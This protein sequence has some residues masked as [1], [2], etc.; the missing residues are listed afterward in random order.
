MSSVT[1]P[2]IL[3]A[4]GGAWF[5]WRCAACEEPVAYAWEPLPGDP[6]TE[7]ADAYLFGRLC[8]RCVLKAAEEVGGAPEDAL[9]RVNRHRRLRAR[10]RHIESVWR[11]WS[12]W[13]EWRA[14]EFYTL[15][16]FA[17]RQ[18]HV[19]HLFH[20]G[21]RPWPT[22]TMNQ[23][24]PRGQQRSASDPYLEMFLVCGVLPVASRAEVRA[25]ATSLSPPGTSSGSTRETAGARSTP[26]SS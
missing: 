14:D 10:Y 21:D 12:L 17:A 4:I 9:Q 2:T 23:W 24:Y 6:D 13:D 7:W 22:L 25:T 26:V 18:Q 20:L 5:H 8:A 15:P 11:G 16:E 19:R 3:D 1:L